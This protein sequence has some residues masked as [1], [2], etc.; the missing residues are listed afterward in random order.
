MTTSSSSSVNR[1][2]DETGRVELKTLMPRPWRG[3][4]LMNNIVETFV[5]SVITD[6]VGTAQDDQWN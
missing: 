5:E 4:L 3:F 6:R 1:L 2:A